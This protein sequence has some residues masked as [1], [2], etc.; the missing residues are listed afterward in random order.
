MNIQNINSSYNSISKKQTTWF[1]KWADLNGHFS[2]EDI[3][4][5]NRHMKRCSTLLIREMQIKPQWN[6]ISHLSEW[7]SSKRPQITNV[8]EDVEKEG[9]WYSVDGNVNW[10][11]HYGNQNRVILLLDIYPKKMKTLN[12]KATCTS[13][14]TEHY[15]QQPRYGSSRSIHQQMNR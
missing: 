4:V 1:K 8:G 3:Q 2:K 15:L 5:A 6:V 13:V 9:T 11:S 12:R 10:C 7:L 14:F